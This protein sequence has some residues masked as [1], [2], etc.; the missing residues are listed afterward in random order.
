MSE[1][2]KKLEE[3]ASLAAR[4]N[5]DVAAELDAVG[6]KI[7]AAPHQ[8]DA[9]RRV[10]MA[11]HPDRPTTL[12]YAQR[13]F[14]DFLELHGDRRYGDDLA[15]VGCGRKR[16]EREN[17][18]FIPSAMQTHGELPKATLGAPRAKFGGQKGNPHEKIVGTP[19]RKLQ[20]NRQSTDQY[21][22]RGGL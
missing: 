2:R 21:F 22:F 15:L 9:W 11:R 5:V 19:L 10:E 16:R 20:G 13:V 12:E 1:L 3:L 14:D 18:N 4:A 17:A 8:E 7:D 6:R